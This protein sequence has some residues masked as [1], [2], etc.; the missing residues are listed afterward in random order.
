[1]EGLHELQDEFA[2]AGRTLEVVGLES[3]RPMSGHPMATRKRRA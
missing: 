2:R 3:H 1:M